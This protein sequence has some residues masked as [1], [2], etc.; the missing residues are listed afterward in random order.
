MDLKGTQTEKNL[1]TAFA[2]ESQARNRY[3][4]SGDIARTAGLEQVAAVFYE[5]A[6]NEGEHARAEFEFLGG[7]GDVKT[8]IEK[9]IRS[10]RLEKEEIYPKFARDARREGFQEIADFF[11]RMSAIEGTHEQR[12]RALLNG[13]HGIEEFKGKTVRQSEVRMAQVMLPDQANPS[14]YVHGGELLKLIDNAAGVVAA[15]HGHRDVVLARIAEVNF[16]AAVEVG[17]LVLIH[18]YLT[19]V[20]RSSMEI[21]IDLD[22]ESLLTGETRRANVAYLIMVAIDDEGKPAEIPP[23]LI[24][25]EEQQRLFEEGKARYEANKKV[26][27]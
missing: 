25:T 11:E 4:F 7:L 14:G 9:A 21:R 20:S 22:A 16:L 27:Q 17:N 2:G 6:T 12:L 10:E 1:L 13:L 18:A 8:N 3:L 24:S 19:F 26:K 15:R 5:L 23:L